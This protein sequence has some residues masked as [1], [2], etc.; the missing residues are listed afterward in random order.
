MVC[1]YDW[2]GERLG[3]VVCQSGGGEGGRDRALS[4]AGC[5]AP[6]VV[7]RRAPAHRRPPG[8]DADAAHRA[9]VAPMR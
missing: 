3:A 6:A 9:H 4:A 7:T 1:L 5:M 8:S 2:C